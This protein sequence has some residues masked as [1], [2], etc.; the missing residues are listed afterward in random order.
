MNANDFRDRIEVWKYDNSDNAG[1]TPIEQYLF[2]RYKYANVKVIGGSTQNDQL[3]NLPYT[4]TVFTIRYDP[5]IDYRCQ[6]KFE[7]VMYKINHIEV[8]DREA[9]MKL[10]AIVYNQEFS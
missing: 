5:I 10:T 4:N 9:Y 8:L 7:N 2:Y 1:G 3:G 6:I